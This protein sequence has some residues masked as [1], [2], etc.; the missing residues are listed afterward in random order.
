MI[1]R[2][3]DIT[4]DYIIDPF[5]PIQTN[6]RK[7]RNA[8]VSFAK[9]LSRPLSEKVDL[10]IEQDIISTANIISLSRALMAGPLFLIF[11]HFDLGITYQMGPLIWAFVSDYIDGV[12]ARKMSQ[13]TDL[14][15]GL[16]AA[17]DKIFAFFVA[18]SYLDQLFYS[19]FNAVA[20]IILDGFLLTLGIML[21]LARKKG[22]YQGKAE[23][24]ANWLGKIKFNLQAGACFCWMNYWT[25]EGH[26]FLLGANLFALGSLIRH[27]SPK[28]KNNETG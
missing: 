3:K 2:V 28:I 8:L 13:V 20:F 10:W 22:H 27:L 18:I 11:T 7:I 19:P 25:T 24:R 5:V 12:L 14:G 17:C 23:V 26:Y 6:R 4:I 15:A 21:Y 9:Y 1:I 16:D